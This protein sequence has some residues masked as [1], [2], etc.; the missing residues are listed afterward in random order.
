MLQS[1]VQSAAIKKNYVTQQSIGCKLPD[2]DMQMSKHVAVQIT[3]ADC[4]DIYCY[5]NCALVDCNKK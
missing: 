3:Q 5:I 1:L 2:D 4:C